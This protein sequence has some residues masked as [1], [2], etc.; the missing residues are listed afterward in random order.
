MYKVEVKNPCSCFIKNGFVEKSEF[1]TQEAAKEEAH[2]LMKIMASNFCQKHQFSMIEQMG[3]F[4]I[5][6]KPR[7]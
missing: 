5:Y 4:I 6:I 1:D 3:N 2:Y 7:N